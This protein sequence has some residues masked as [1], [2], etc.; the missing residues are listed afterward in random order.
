MNTTTT[1][2]TFLTVFLIQNTQNC[3]A[4]AV[5]VKLDGI[6]RA[7]NK[8]N[9]DLITSEDDTQSELQE[10]KERYADLSRRH[11]DLS[12]RQNALAKPQSNG[13]KT[14]NGRTG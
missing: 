2:V 1:V 6:I 8:A 5:H 3:D 4:M 11:A 13:H 7:R 9:N 14:A 10:L 12:E